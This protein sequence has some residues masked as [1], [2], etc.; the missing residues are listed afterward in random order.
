IAVGLVLAKLDWAMGAPGRVIAILAVSLPLPIVTVL[1]LARQTQR[2]QE[3]ADFRVAQAIPD[4]HFL[5]DTL[6]KLEEV[7]R[8]AREAEW[9]VLRE[10]SRSERLK[11]LERRLGVQG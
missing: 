8:A 10:P 3:T 4:P 2:E 5:P 1:V 6:R 7:Q 11:R 9:G